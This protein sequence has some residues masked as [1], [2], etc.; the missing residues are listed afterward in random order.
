M[1]A[2]A[3]EIQSVARGAE[4]LTRSVETTVAGID[5]LQSASQRLSGGFQ[6]LAEAISGT[7]ATAEEMT[8]AIDVVA[9]RSSDLRDG[10]DQSAAT[11]EQMAASVETTA[12]HAG[13]LISSV[14]KTAEVVAGLV[15]T[16]QQ[17]GHEVRQVEHLSR[18]ATEEV[19]A[20][21][22][23]VRS[24]L[25]AMGRIA[26][27]IHETAAFMRELEIHSRDIR[28][29]L[30][31]IEEIADQT[32]LLALN[33]A[34]EAARAGDAGRGFAVVADE[35]RKL[36]ERSVSAAKEIGEVVRLV[37]E[38]TDEAARCPGRGRDA[39]R[40]APR[41]SRGGG[42]EVDPRRCRSD[43]E[44]GHGA[45]PPGGR[46]G[47]GLRRRVVGRGRDARDHAARHPGRSRAGPRR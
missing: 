30:E 29:I 15:A 35:V 22:E 45:R 17:L 33:A 6:E 42:L 18:R 36:A 31:V 9:A 10:V 24:A 27:G 41:R 20:G 13:V 5:E 40:D 44:A 2:I 3:A 12:Q 4:S 39:R 7:S 26:G 21:D 1:A 23:A 38:R 32:N 46:P 8:R 37:Q 11:V 19:A 14:S 34:I 43:V 16:G 47:H 28:K 25:M